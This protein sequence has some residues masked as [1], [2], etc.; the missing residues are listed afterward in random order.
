MDAVELERV[1]IK[2][3]SEGDPQSVSL[4]ARRRNGYGYAVYLDRIQ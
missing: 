2:Q 1:E 3:I 4:R